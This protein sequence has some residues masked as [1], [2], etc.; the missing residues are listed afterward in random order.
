MQTVAATKDEDGEKGHVE[1]V[2][3]ERTPVSGGNIS[4]SSP[5]QQRH[6]LSISWGSVEENKWCEQ[7]WGG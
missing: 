4:R 6:T 2:L 3:R 5:Q 1:L 7:G